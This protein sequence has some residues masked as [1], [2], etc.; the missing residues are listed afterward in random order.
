M[1]WPRV[2]TTFHPRPSPGSHTDH[3]DSCPDHAF[4]RV[5]GNSLIFYLES[6]TEP[7]SW[8][9]ENLSECFPERFASERLGIAGTPRPVDALSPIRADVFGRN[10]VGD[11]IH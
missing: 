10:A 11:L 2:G 6:R 5:S 3:L 1:L 7:D 4:A 8:Q 9:A